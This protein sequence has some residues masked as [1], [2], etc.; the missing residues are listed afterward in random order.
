MMKNLL[1]QV[2]LRSKQRKHD[3]IA[4]IIINTAVNRSSICRKMAAMALYLRLWV[5]LTALKLDN[6]IHHL[7]ATFMVVREARQACTLLINMR[8]AHHKGWAVDFHPLISSLMGPLDPLPLDPARTEDLCKGLL[9]V[10][11]K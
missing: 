1:I 4:D 8:K 7:M 5:A 2:F 6:F 9:E 3:A 10:R 11:H